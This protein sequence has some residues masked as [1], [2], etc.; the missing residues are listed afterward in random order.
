[1]SMF[2]IECS[3]LYI[4]HLFSSTAS[5][6]EIWLKRLKAEVKRKLS[7]YSIYPSLRC[8]QALIA[9][10][11]SCWLDLFFLPGHW[12][13]VIPSHKDTQQL[14][15]A[16]LLEGLFFFPYFFPSSWH[17]TILQGVSPFLACYQFCACVATWSTDFQLPCEA[18][19][20]KS[21]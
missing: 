4:S 3:F 20:R 19:F 16:L 11:H 12:Q 8:I 9:F 1:M 7:F 17:R 13:C 18:E 2:L 5:S 10:R 6:R 15:I 14:W 21:V